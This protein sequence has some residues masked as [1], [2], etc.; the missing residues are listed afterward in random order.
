MADAYSFR[1][2]GQASNGDQIE[3]IILWKRDMLKKLEE[4]QPTRKGLKLLWKEQ[5]LKGIK[6]DTWLI[7]P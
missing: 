2:P 7:K 6:E 4:E 1:P 3:W 5:V